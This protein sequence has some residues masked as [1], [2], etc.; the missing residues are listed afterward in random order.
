MLIKEKR[1]VKWFSHVAASAGALSA[2]LGLLVMI[3]WHSHTPTL[4]QVH[5]SF[6]AM[7][8]NTALGFLLCGAAVALL[9]LGRGRRWALAGGLYGSTFGLLTLVE[10]LFDI[11]LGI[12][13]LL[14]TPYIIT[15]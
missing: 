13:R 8:Y 10:H 14:M 4:I 7:V 15:G 6:A 9:A 3:G 5:P 2:A 1:L 12:D 11:H